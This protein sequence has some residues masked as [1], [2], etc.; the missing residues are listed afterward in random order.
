LTAEAVAPAL[1]PNFG[2]LPWFEGVIEGFDRAARSYRV[3]ALNPENHVA[4]SWKDDTMIESS[5][6]AARIRFDD[7]VE[8]HAGRL[9]FMVGDKVQLS[10]RHNPATK[11]TTAV[12]I[13]GAK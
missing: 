2:G 1:R 11:A 8:T 6:G 13:I 4:I 12:V 7:Y 9:P 3:R 5:P 10:W